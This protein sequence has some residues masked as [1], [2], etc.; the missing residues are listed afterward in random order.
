MSNDAVE[1]TERFAS[2]L[3][4]RHHQP[5]VPATAQANSSESQDGSHS[6]RRLWE[7]SDLPAN[8]FAD[9]VA[10]FYNLPRIQ[11]PQLLAASPLLGQFSRRFL[12]DMAAFPYRS[13]EGQIRLA[14]AD[15]SDTA[16][17]RA[18]EIVLDGPI[19][20]DIASF[21][22]LA[23]ALTERLGDDDASAPA[24]GET[25]H[26][27]NDDDIES[28]RDLASGAP[29]VRGVNELL[30]KAV[31]LRASDIHLAP[32]RSGLMVRMRIDGLL[33][34]VPAPA[35]ALP[36]A[37]ISRIKIIAGLNIAE[38]RLPQD[39]AARLRVGKSELDIRVAIMPTQH[40]ES[41]VIRLLPRDR[42]L[43]AI[44]K[45]GLSAGDRVKLARLIELPHGMIV[46]TGPTGSGKTTT[47]ATILSMLNEPTRKIL[48]VEDPVEYE[49]AG[50]DQT[51]IKPAIGLTFA[52]ALRAFVRQD[53]DVI[54]VGEVRDSETAHIAIHAALTGHLVLTTLHT[55]TAAAAIPRLLD[56]GVEA[57]LLKSTLRAVIAQRL[58]R[59]LCERCKVRK[60]LTLADLAAEP[61][62][63]ALGLKAGETVHEP[64]GCERCGGTGYRG[65]VGVFELLEMTPN[66]RALVDKDT[67]SASIDTSAVAAGMTTMVEDGTTKCRAGATSAAEILRVTTIR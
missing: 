18:A 32:A 65:R 56:L 19:A 8:E 47:L 34:A 64:G 3:R 14:L 63:P 9:E 5:S 66:I 28:L 7:Q 15:P 23:T 54:M 10:R 22:D 11:L 60:T 27:R 62:Y 12:R 48:T 21:E 6:L 43:L 30:E 44:D 36:Q 53:P 4:D 67:D 31:E 59:Q 49:I 41:A 17:V 52:A 35:D 38:R 16:S 2:Y 37:V 50:I 29:V 33:R 58:V 24:D 46:V 26:S 40:G 57:F 1:A 45:L 25:A 55:E 13:A 39:G 51:Q 61:R 20:I 42:G